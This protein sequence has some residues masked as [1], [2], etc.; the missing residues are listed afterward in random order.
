MQP[1][2]LSDGEAAR[3]K[4]Y[5]E[6]KYVDLDTEQRRAIWSDAAHRVIDSRLPSFPDEVKEKVRFELLDKQRD[7]LII[8]QDDAL[9]ECLTL[10]LNQSELLG[11][12]AVW[13]GSR[14]AMPL[15]GESLRDTL[16]QWS[17]RS[18][19]QISLKALVEAG[20]QASAALQQMNEPGCASEEIAAAVETASAGNLVN[21]AEVDTST[22]HRNWRVRRPWAIMAVMSSCM[23][24]AIFLVFTMNSFRNEQPTS[25]IQT[26]PSVMEMMLRDIRE[27]ESLRRAGGIP[28]ELRYV[29]V[30]KK[31]LSRFLQDR[32]SLLAEE[33]YLSAILASAKRYDV[34]PLLLFAITG[35]EQGFVPKDQKQAKQIANN[36]FNVFGSWESYNT[37]IEVSAD[38]A[39]K[40]VKNIS[41]RRP[42]DD[43]PIQWLNQTY[44]EDPEWWTGVTWL[45]NTMRQ[46]IEGKSFEWAK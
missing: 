10:D 29:D 22:V 46:Q 20:P 18:P 15:E 14:S 21:T 17:R 8:H 12:L 25:G 36:P 40:T 1:F 41:R 3:L 42:G 35:Q 33:P 39:A 4:K 45:L 5:I 30:D 38:I 43:H 6:K 37:T 13:V 9:R 26:Y 24:A 16:L 27:R 44:A 31:R 11:A 2:I 7:T 23:A 32:N 19:D 34:H 28:A